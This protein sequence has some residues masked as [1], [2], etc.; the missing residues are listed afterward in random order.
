MTDTDGPRIRPFADFL[1]EHNN[2]LGHNLAGEKL[3]EL[4]AAVRDTGKKGRLTLTLDV[5]AMDED[6]LVTV[7]EVAVKC[8]QPPTKAAVF[9]ADDDGN[10]TRTDPKQT[11]LP[12]RE[13]PG[14][15]VQVDEA[16]LKEV[17]S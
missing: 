15:G 7:L 16:A 2:G 5:T 13:V 17:Q 12:L 6:T 4:V 10:L 3:H 8:P 11:H 9:F 1:I 14:G